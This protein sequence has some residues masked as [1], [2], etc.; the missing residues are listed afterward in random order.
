MTQ[1][2]YNDKTVKADAFDCTALH[3]IQ[4]FEA[5]TLLRPNDA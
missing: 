1:K 3:E 2:L 5:E 4:S